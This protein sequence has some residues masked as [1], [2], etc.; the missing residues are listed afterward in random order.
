MYCLGGVLD[1]KEP[2]VALEVA[3]HTREGF[4]DSSPTI[5]NSTPGV[6]LTNDGMFAGNVRLSN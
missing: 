6:I 2:E 5:T 1:E 4:D 3:D